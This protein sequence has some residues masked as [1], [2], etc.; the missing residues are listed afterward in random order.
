MATGTAI[1]NFAGAAPGVLS[2]AS[3]DVAGQAGIAAGSLVEAWVRPVASAEHSADEHVVE[4]LKIV[5]GN[6]VAGTGF[7]V[8]AEIANGKSYGNWNVNWVWV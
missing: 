5:A 6:I 3:L 8:Y 1:V 4:Q 7:T 2:Q